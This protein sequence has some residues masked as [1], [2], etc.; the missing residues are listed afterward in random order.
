MRPARR[1]GAARRCLAAAAALLG[2]G[3]PGPTPAAEVPAFAQV[4][5]AWR[6][7]ETWLL[8]RTGAPLQ[9]LRTDAR[10]R[11]LAWTP[12]AQVS[13]ALRAA[14]VAAE[15][16][17]FAEHDGVDWPAALQA[18]L[19]NL[20]GAR[21]RGASTI[22]MQLAGL[23][24]PA[25][26]RGE[27]G[28][29]VAQKVAQVRAALALEKRWTKD[30]ILE[31]Y[32][33]LA[34]FRGELEGV[35]AMSHGLFGKAPHGLDRREAA[36]AAALL[37]APTAAPARVAERACALLARDRAAAPPPRADRA[38]CDGLAEQARQA[39]ARGHAAFPR[40][41]AAP[42]AARRLFAAAAARPG[43]RLA[44][45]LDAGVQAA[46]RAAL[47]ARLT[48]LAGRNVEDGA[49]VVLDNAS[50]EVLAYVGSSGDL[51]QAGAVDH[52]DA[53]RQAG[54]TLK[55][56][57]Y[58]LAI[59]ERRL[60]A[61][62]VL[63]DAPLQ[64]PTAGGLYAPRN[65]SAAYRG[66]VSLRASLGASLNVPA[67]RTLV[68]VGP[69]R[70]LA[71]LRDAGLDTLTA[72]G[73]HYGY[74]LA[75]GGADVTL[76]QLTNAY[77]M[78]ANDGMWSAPRLTAGAAAAPARRVY[79]AAA[80]HI[81]ADILADRAAR[82]AT[83]GLANPLETPFWSA[84]KTGTSKDMR[85][86]WAIGFSRRHT[87]GVWVGNAGGSPM[88]DVSGVDGAAPVWHDLMLTLHRRA[89]AAAAPPAAPPGVVAQR[90]RFEPPIEPP[91]TE[92]FTAGSARAVVRLAD[93]GAAGPRIASPTAGAIVAL[94]PDI[95]PDRQRLLFAAS[96]AAALR[97]QLDGRVLGAAARA[98][99][100]FP[101]PGRHTLRLVDDRGTVHDEASFEVRGAT[102][103]SAAP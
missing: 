37:R 64:L 91:R 49:V 5:A 47:R 86:N 85:D 4:R 74:A 98:H 94:D 45:T 42:H 21:M 103:R 15:D 27:D 29:S 90:V 59:E 24:D 65:Y 9:R 93:P 55:P 97:W 51:S 69:D 48:E 84:V 89:P 35:A 67:V 71:R 13:P 30:Q 66:P 63:D 1:A 43:A 23:L 28:R 38:P 7:S 70:L 31:A 36:L 14:V 92:L 39:L 101:Q 80:A 25:L 76:L 96:G 82:A 95:P 44:S 8:D 62:S 10:V 12:L 87:V 41:D 78:L 34:T 73:D 2:L 56:F 11:R 32:L 100:W 16:Q 75:L 77:R 46:A 19:D 58:A 54:S 102:R 3:A 79:A 99:A 18:A 22:S 20:G 17:R 33:N 57:L 50:G 52:A 72:T 6:A 26:A 83:F 81:V 61:A 53:P 68:M 88:H 60:T 40:E